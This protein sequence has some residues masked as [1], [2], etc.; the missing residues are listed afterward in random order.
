[1]M[2]TS[3]KSENCIT[4]RILG[5]NGESIK[6]ATV[7]ALNGGKTC[8][9]PEGRFRLC[10]DSFSFP[11][12]IT[13]SL[14]NYETEDIQV[15]SIDSSIVVFLMPHVYEL[16]EVAVV[17][18][19]SFERKSHV[20][21]IIVNSQAIEERMP[22]H[23]GEMLGS[24]S[25][26]TQRS[27]YQTPLILRGLSGKRLLVLRNGN[28][29]FSSYPSGFMSQTI[30]VYDLDKIEVE[31]GAASV[32]YGTGAIA[33]VVNLIDKSP[34]EQHGWNG[35][36]VT[37]YATNNS[38]KSVLA[39]GSWSNG[40]LA[41][42]TNLRYRDANAFHYPDGTEA[43][44]SF[45]ADKDLFITT[46]YQPNNRQT[47]SLSADLHRGGPWGKPRGF[48]GTKYM[49]ATANR[50]DNNNYSFNYTFSGKGILKKLAVTSYY[51]D[52]LR[53]LERRYFA[54][55]G[56]ILSFQE[57]T[58]YS[59]HYYGGKVLADFQFT[60]KLQL[61]AGTEGYGFHLSSPTESVDYIEGLS[62]KN[63]VAINAR[64]FNTGLFAE[65]NYHLSAKLKLT[66]G[67]RGD[68]NT[69]YQGEVHDLAQTGENKT[70]VSALSGNLAMR[71]E[72]F[73][74]ASIKLNLSRSFRMPDAGELF[75]DSYTSRGI[76]FG[77]DKLSPEYSYGLDGSL[78]LNKR[79]IEAELSPFIWLIDDMI[80]LEEVKG[81]P[82]TNFQYINIGQARLWGG[83]AI[84]TIPL[85]NLILKNDRLNTS[86]AVAYVNG[87]DVST[88]NG[89]L[90]TGEPLDFIPPFNLKSEVNYSFSK[91][92][93]FTGNFLL[94]TT[95]Y[96]QQ[97]R[98]PNDGY[99]TPAYLLF[100]VSMGATFQKLPTK[101]ALRLVVNNVLNANYY[102]FQSYLPSEGQS[103]R[104]FLTLAFR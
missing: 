62:F 99:V 70:N 78:T 34:F 4:G 37:G 69:I 61:R 103:I 63:R 104:V 45:Y 24:K 22:M 52:E 83:E 71:N 74:S 57:T 8:C 55:A 77:N 13:V 102:S 47:F 1:M 68:I 50:E 29:R 67:L 2:V 80:T 26:F 31:K 91:G 76:L 60:P 64:S 53:E 35:K 84:L 7:V 16:A 73:H 11:T 18:T 86:V 48:N 23:V 92:G 94:A 14:L 9:D 3:L 72:S 85:S 17:G 46:G 97:K 44:N 54:A 43:E 88:S 38:E 19:G 100:D 96:T 93:S 10:A 58:Y 39:S 32:C 28:R 27:G 51:S 42:K 49:L 15:E 33:G 40:K 89:F 12:A 87:T 79:W 21:T 36:L 81:Q 98:L 25:G 95:W 6:H 30:N 65:T 41:V 20:S 5:V 59:D 56:M 82:G 75:T 101:P 90:K 66:A